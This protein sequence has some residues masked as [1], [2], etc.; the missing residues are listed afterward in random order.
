MNTW[1]EIDTNLKKKKA[2]YQ[3][4][5]IKFSETQEG[6]KDNAE[7]CCFLK[8]HTWIPAHIFKLPF[9]KLLKPSWAYSC[10]FRWIQFWSLCLS[11]NFFHSVLFTMEAQVI[12]SKAS[13]NCF[14]LKQ[15][16]GPG[17]T[18]I[19]PNSNSWAPGQRSHN[20]YFWNNSNLNIWCIFHNAA[21]WTCGDADRT[22]DSPGSRNNHENLSADK[23]H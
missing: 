12:F 23:N 18:E 14:C 7:E 6:P 16:P 11:F 15:V 22:P 4:L 1:M 13:G 2:K 5:F 21:P 3:E 20:F 17:R 9:Q 10:E 19:S 8:K